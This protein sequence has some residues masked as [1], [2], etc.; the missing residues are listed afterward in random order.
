[1]K[2]AVFHELHDGGARR[3]VN[4]FSKR[5]LVKDTVD[6]YIVDE[7]YPDSEKNNFTNVYYYEFK[8]K[9]WKSNNWKIRLYKDTFELFKLYLL[10]R[11]IAKR[12]N[13]GNYDLAF[14]HPSRY[15]QAPFILRFVKCKKF[16][17]CQEPLRLV[18]DPIFKMKDELHLIKKIYEVM[19]RKLRKFID[20]KNVDFADVIFANSRFSKKN[21]FT[22]YGRKSK[23]VYLGVDTKLFKPSGI[24]RSIDVLYIGGDKEIDGFDLLKEAIRY[25]RKKPNMEI[26]ISGKNWISD[27]RLIELYNKSKIVVCLAKNEPFGL[28]PVEAM[29][30]GA[31][32]IAVNEGGYKESVIDNKSGFLIP[33]SPLLLAE[34]IDLCLENSSM[35]KRF[36]KSGRS[37]V[38]KRWDWDVQ[39]FKL[40]KILHENF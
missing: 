25:S 36:G 1:M 29:S 33:R 13:K 17:Y 5:L 7:N 32:V 23:V 37:E 14:I 19:I 40:S 3:A 4:E 39:T 35:A 20:R 15:T 31:L 38:I 30:C 10:H 24:I 26:Q 34:K 11:K 2:I 9:N 8:Q 27:R 12:I 21:I 28:I 6:L 16:Y 18:Y 22:A